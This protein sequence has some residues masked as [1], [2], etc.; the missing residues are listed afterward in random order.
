MSKTF[1]LLVMKYIKEYIDKINAMIKKL[2]EALNLINILAFDRARVIVLE[3]IKLDTEADEYRREIIEKYLP[4]IPD[5]VIR[6]NIRIFLRM[7]DHVSEWLKL[8]L[9][10]IDLV[11]IMNIPSDIRDQIMSLFKL[12]RNGIEVLRDSID[13]LEKK[14]FDEAYRYGI[15]LEKI[16]EEADKILH[17]AQR[18]LIDVANKIDNIAYILF[19]NELLKALETATDYEEDAGDIIRSLSLSL[20]KATQE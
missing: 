2:E 11:P 7:L 8:S 15:K 5:L 16:E 10:Y 14:R 4:P 19:I 9:R 12:A 20:S 6:E 18:K 3:A 13:M 1:Y 17:E